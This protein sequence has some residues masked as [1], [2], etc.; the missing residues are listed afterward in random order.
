VCAFSFTS[1]A[2][3]AASHS[4]RETILGCSIVFSFCG[5]QVSIPGFTRSAGQ[6]RNHDGRDAAGG[7]DASG[8]ADD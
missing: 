6:V 7:R 3:R 1:S 5:S 4:S 8:K 2:L